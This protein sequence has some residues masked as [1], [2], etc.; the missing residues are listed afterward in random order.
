MFYMTSKGSCPIEKAGKLGNWSKVEIT[1]LA[2][3]AGLGLF[4]HEIFLKRND[5]LKN[6]RN[7]LNMKIIG[8]K[9]INMSDKMVY[10]AMFSTTFDKIL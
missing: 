5:P 6:L 1:P 7:K 8:T 4:E 9:P 2:P 10:L 3:L